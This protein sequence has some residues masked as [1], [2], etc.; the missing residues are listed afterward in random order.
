MKDINNAGHL[1][2]R[3]GDALRA[4]CSETTSEGVRQW[5]VDNHSVRVSARTC[6]A[7]RSRD[8][9][10][11]GRLLRGEDVEAEVGE[12][13]RLAQYRGCFAD[14]AAVGLLAEQLAE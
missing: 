14:A 6:E 1:E 11:A 3:Y 9:S 13:L 8:W 10:T 4:G 5:M 2:L 12:R 7:W